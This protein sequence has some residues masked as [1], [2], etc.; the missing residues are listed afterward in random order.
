MRN[1]M[2]EPPNI[3]F[4]KIRKIGYGISLSLLILSF[5][6]FFTRGFNLGL[7]FTGGT[8]IQVKFNQQMR[9]SDVRN[10]LKDVDLA[11]SLIQEVGTNKDE[12]EIRVPAKKGSSS[13]V[14]EKVKKALDSKYQGRYEIRKVE[15][16]DALVGSEMAK[17]SVYSM[18]FVMLGIL[19]FVGYRYEPLFAIAAVIPLF[20]DAIITLG[21]FSLLG[22]EID[23]TVIAAI[24][25]VLGYSLNDTIIV[26]DRI[27]ENIK[28]RGR[29]N[30]ESII[31]RS[32]N[33]NLARTIITSGT[34]LFSVIAIYF[35]GGES[36]QNFALALLIGIVFGTYSS[37]YVAG[38]LILEVEKILREKTKKETVGA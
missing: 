36:L 8:S 29:K 30:M 31:N 22:K 16:I 35:F 19:L 3:D 20:H 34:A 25:T 5:V 33:E 23:L 9:V 17:A 38:P 11:D 32:I 26:F 28:A 2:V 37:I 14:L 12:V 15:F 10:L 13:V 18:I 27:R 7:D 4:L 6:L 1:F 21:I 24:L